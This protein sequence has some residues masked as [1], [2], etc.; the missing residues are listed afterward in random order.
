[1]KHLRRL[2]TRP[3]L[4]A[5]LL[6][7]AVPAWAQTPSPW[8]IGMQTSHSPVE[9]GIQSLHLLVNVL[10]IAIV[11]FVAALLGYVIW[12]FN[13][14]RHPVASRISH[15]TILEVAWTV[16]PSSSWS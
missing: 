13:S 16:L 4:A 1:M 5:A 14:K 15:N 3:A 6:A 7:P 9:S 2:L 12:R 11:I 8:A 10:M